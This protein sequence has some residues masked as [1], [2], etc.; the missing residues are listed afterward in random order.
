M[1]QK[2]A[3]LRERATAYPDA[4]EAPIVIQWNG[5]EGEASP[6]FELAVWSSPKL[7]LPVAQVR[8]GTFGGG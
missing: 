4:Q 1:L 8:G 6:T 7:S 3:A 2:L 5:N